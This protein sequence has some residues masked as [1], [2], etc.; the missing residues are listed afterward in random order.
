M[1]SSPEVKWTVGELAGRFGLESHVLRHWEDVGLMAPERDHAG[2]RVY[3]EDD[4]YRVAV[5]LT[6]KASGMSLDQI[7]T[8]IDAEADGR[9]EALKAHLVELDRR[10]AEIERSRRMTEHALECRAHDIATCP[11]FRA[12]VGDI[13]EGTRTGF[14]LPAQMHE[15]R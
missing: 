3:R 13:V 11:G 4:A 8:L 15:R 7:R 9:R 10:Q 6:S 5:I 12:H 1:K 14:P 2:R